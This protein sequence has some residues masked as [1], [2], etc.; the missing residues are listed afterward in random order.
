MRTVGAILQGGRSSRMG[1]DKAFVV[2]DGVP[3]RE[4]VRRALAAVVDEVVQLGGVAGGV[5]DVVVDAGDGPLLA[6]LALLRS[7]RGD[8][9]LV[10]AVDQP[11]L[12]EALLR[13]LLEVDVGTE[14]GVAFVDEP[15]PCVLAAGARGRIEAVA[16][17]GERRLG[18]LTTTWLAPTTDERR[19][20]ANVNSP[21]DLRAVRRGDG[22]SV[23]ES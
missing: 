11:L 8:R 20:L 4:R 6:V 23:P 5:E 16:R 12:D 22:S 17:A 18:A 13:R 7:G 15:V 10:A 2:V 9:Y 14:G 21:D 3:M 19:R 1:R